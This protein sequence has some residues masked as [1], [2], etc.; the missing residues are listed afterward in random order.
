MGAD[1]QDVGLLNFH[2]LGTALKIVHQPLVMAVNGDRQQLLGAGLANDVLVQLANDLAGR[3][4]AVEELAG[5]TA[6]TSFLVQNRLHSS[7]HSPQM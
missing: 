2:I 5:A 4:D 1:Q 3:G 7:M 6:S